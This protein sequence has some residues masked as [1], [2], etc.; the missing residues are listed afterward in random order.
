MRSNTCAFTENSSAD[1]YYCYCT[2]I[3]IIKTIYQRGVVVLFENRDQRRGGSFFLTKEEPK[4][5]TRTVD[6]E[7]EST[8]PVLLLL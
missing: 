5:V 3:Y 2:N 7:R 1:Q 8:S 4:T 6:Q